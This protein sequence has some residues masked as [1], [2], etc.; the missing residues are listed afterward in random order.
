MTNLILTDDQAQK[1]IIGFKG[2]DTS[3]LICEAEYKARQTGYEMTVVRTT[4]GL[5][6]FSDYQLQVA[7]DIIQ[8]VIY[9]A[10]SGFIYPMEA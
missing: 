9:K 2:G 6:V 4:N 10:T 3:K 7:K 1:S 5:A 8:E